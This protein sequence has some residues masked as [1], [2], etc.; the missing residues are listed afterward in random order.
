[1]LWSSRGT[2]A[3]PHTPTK[4]NDRFSVLSI[5]VQIGLEEAFVAL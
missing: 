1:M 4:V 5:P 2:R 3:S